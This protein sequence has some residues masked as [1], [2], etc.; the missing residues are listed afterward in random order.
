MLLLTDGLFKYFSLASHA[1]RCCCRALACSSISSVGD[2]LAASRG[3]TFLGWFSLSLC[4]AP[5]LTSAFLST[6]TSFP[7]SLA[8]LS[9][10]VLL[11]GSGLFLGFSACSP[12]MTATVSGLDP[13]SRSSTS[14]LFSTPL[15]AFVFVSFLFPLCLACTFSDDVALRVLEKLVN[16]GEDDFLFLLPFLIGLFLFSSY[17]FPAPSAFLAFCSSD[18]LCAASSARTFLLPCAPPRAACFI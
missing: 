5:T 11:R 14:A 4:E 18:F 15:S 2:T 13:S 17:N 10:A 12:K 9:S 6:F 1:L 16:V 7:V 8:C 3:G